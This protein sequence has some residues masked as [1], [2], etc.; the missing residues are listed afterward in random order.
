[1]P[2]GLG[3]GIASYL[4]PARVGRSSLDS[5]SPLTFLV[6]LLFLFLLFFWLQM[7]LSL[8]KIVHTWSE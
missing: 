1:M 4:S 3:S 2:K 5:A 6:C 7:Y 8:K